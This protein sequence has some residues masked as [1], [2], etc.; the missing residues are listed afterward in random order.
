MCEGVVQA[1]VRGGHNGG[2]GGLHD[3]QDD[4]LGVDDDVIYNSDK[5]DSLSQDTSICSVQIALQLPPPSNTQV[6]E[7]AISRG[8][9]VLIVDDLL[10]TGGTM[11]AASS[12][13]RRSLFKLLNYLKMVL[14]ADL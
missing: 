14:G 10:A 11:A 4:V 12:L 6:Q 1:G 9:R 3:G 5:S 13:V 7:G 2:E 8:S